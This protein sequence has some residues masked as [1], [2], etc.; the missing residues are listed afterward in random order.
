MITSATM[1]KLLTFHEGY[2]FRE[3]KTLEIAILNYRPL[4][5]LFK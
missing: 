2:A 1:L 3:S 4:V 5:L